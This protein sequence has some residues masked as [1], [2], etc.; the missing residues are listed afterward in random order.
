M[1]LEGSQSKISPINTQLQELEAFYLLSLIDDFL[2]N[3]SQ[4]EPEK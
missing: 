1:F 4:T 3:W 2:E